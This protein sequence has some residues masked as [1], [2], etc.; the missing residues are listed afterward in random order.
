VQEVML[1]LHEKYGH[2]S[3]IEDL[4][5]LS[6][7]ILR[8]KMTG[9]RRKAERR[10]ESR[11]VSLEDTPVADPNSNPEKDLARRELLERLAKA[12]EQT[13]E[14]CRELFRLK[15]Q[16]KSYQEIQ[17]LMGVRSINTIYTWDFRC[18]RHLLELMGGRWET[19]R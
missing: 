5:P 16:G 17:S 19:E 18:R 6:F 4:L 12:L 2:L 15:L 3:R 9:H 1:V 13:G 11:R 14:R 10:G 8:F 7:Q